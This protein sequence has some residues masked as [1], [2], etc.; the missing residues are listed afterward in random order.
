MAERT[1][2]FVDLAGFTALTEAHGD[3]EAVATLARFK[4]MAS[5]ALGPNDVLVKTIGDAVMVAF[6]SPTTAVSSLRR[7]FEAARV[8]PTMPLMRA[9]VHHGSAIEDEGD[10]FGAAVNLAA[11]VAAQASGGQLLAT[12]TVA[13]AATVTGEVVTHLGTISLRNIAE[14]VDVYEVD[15]DPDVDVAVD[16]VCAMKVP[17]TGPSRIQLRLADRD[18]WFCGL[19]CVAR[20]AAAPDRYQSPRRP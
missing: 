9:G 7:L 6:E 8:E 16:P 19:P 3:D 11:R 14:P 20:Y 15:L 18:V 17:T 1:F 12:E 4:Q 2:A 10:F 13:V 5:G